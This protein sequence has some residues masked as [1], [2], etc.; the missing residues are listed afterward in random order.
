[1]EEK[2]MASLYKTLIIDCVKDYKDEFDNSLIKDCSNENWKEMVRLYKKLSD[3]D[4][5]VFFSI[6]KTV[7]NDA[8]AS[9]LGGIDG[10]FTLI[11]FQDELKL[12]ANGK[13]LEDLQ[14]T[15]YM[16]VEDVLGKKTNEP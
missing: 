5:E 2:L 13:T 14:D 10:S 1:M 3:S 8:I 9:F 6:I 7:I 12:T 16:Y 4:K 11:D 15:W